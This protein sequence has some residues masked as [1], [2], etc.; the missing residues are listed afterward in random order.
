MLIG[1]Y[2]HYCFWVPR[3]VDY[4]LITYQTLRETNKM[5]SALF[6]EIALCIYNVMTPMSEM[7]S[8]P[9]RELH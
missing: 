5:M 6:K 3:H 8:T 1:L 2:G 4:S 9:T 7:N